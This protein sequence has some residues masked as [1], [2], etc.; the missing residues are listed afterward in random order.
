MVTVDVTPI[1]GG[2]VDIDHVGSS[3][4][5]N[6]CTFDADPAVVVGREQISLTAVPSSGFQ[7]VGWSGDLSGDVNPATVRVV[8][9]MNITAN[10]AQETNTLI[11]SS[12]GNGSTT[13]SV[14]THRYP[15]GATIKI[16]AVPDEGWQFDG[17][18]SDVTEPESTD[19]VLTM[20]SDKTIH[21]SFSRGSSGFWLTGGIIGALIIIG[22]AGWLLVKRR[23]A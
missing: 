14:G 6:T 20:D 19:V 12:D 15:Q 5:P 3:F 10:F 4:Y 2:F 11:I 7:F 18:T 23:T 22:L 13:P 21:V 1:A 17:W 16:T 8:L 9:N